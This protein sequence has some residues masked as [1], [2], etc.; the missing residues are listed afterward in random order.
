MPGDL[1]YKTDE[2]LHHERRNFL[3]NRIRSYFFGAS[4]K[5]S[6]KEIKRL[7]DEAIKEQDEL[8]AAE[9]DPDMQKE[10][11]RAKELLTKRFEGLNTIAN[12][13][14]IENPTNPKDY[15][16]NDDIEILRRSLDNYNLI[17][18]RREI[19]GAS[20]DVLE[21][22]F[23]DLYTQVDKRCDYEMDNHYDV[24]FEQQMLRKSW[25]EAL[26]QE[27]TVNHPN[28][29]YKTSGDY[30][31]EQDFLGNIGTV[32][33][34]LYT[35]ELTLPGLQLYDYVNDP[36]APQKT[37]KELFKTCGRLP[38]ISER[39]RKLY[40]DIDHTRRSKDIQEEYKSYLDIDKYHEIGSFF[41]DSKS[42]S[43]YKTRRHNYISGSHKDYPASYP[44]FS[45]LD[46]ALDNTRKSRISPEEKIAAED[47]LLKQYYN[48]FI[49]NEPLDAVNNIWHRG[50][51]AMDKQTMEKAIAA[52]LCSAYYKLEGNEK[53]NEN[54]MVFK[55]IVSRPVNDQTIKDT[56]DYFK[57]EIY[58][59]VYDNDVLENYQLFDKL[60]MKAIKRQYDANI[61]NREMRNALDSRYNIHDE[62]HA[63]IAA[64]S[65]L[66]SGNN[67]K[68]KAFMISD[69]SKS[70]E[71]D[72]LKRFVINQIDCNPKLADAIKE[73]ISKETGSYG[74]IRKSTLE[75]AEKFIDDYRFEYNLTNEDDSK[76]ISQH[77]D[78][79]RELQNVES[80][81]L[82]NSEQ[83]NRFRANLE[84]SIQKDYKT[85]PDTRK[86]DDEGGISW[87]DAWENIQKQFAVSNG[88]LV[89]V[90][91]GKRSREAFLNSEEVVRE[92]ERLDEIGKAALQKTKK[93]DDGLTAQF[94]TI[95]GTIGEVT[96]EISKESVLD[97]LV[98]GIGGSDDVKQARDNMITLAKNA[99][100]NFLQVFFRMSRNLTASALRNGLNKLAKMKEGEKISQAEI[101][102]LR[103][104]ALELK[105]SI[106]QGRTYSETA[107]WVKKLSDV[108]KA[109]YKM[110]TT[111]LKN[112]DKM[113]EG[114]SI[115][116]K[117]V[118][119]FEKNAKDTAAPTL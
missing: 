22:F 76:I 119:D 27:M 71:Y 69:M 31:E 110:A 70:D 58:K 94:S 109:R 43:T 84:K 19:K 78:K 93:T 72:G 89:D 96:P 105:S 23:K 75:L 5:D 118:E 4:L 80:R 79:L 40:L 88:G 91:I 113:L 63:Y 57:N 92:K 86:K 32:V 6:M 117:G 85:N 24:P 60:D 82:T 44:D 55:H 13:L 87:R 100:R 116:K 30:S 52:H 20:E 66:L 51:L 61:L 59:D 34:K 29:Y 25:I 104:K 111:I 74:D 14:A 77:D 68:N 18:K 48:N 39:G 38:F 12:K 56:I 17:F 73:Q 83:F 16:S 49:K 47:T 103:V 41:D 64:M 50:P 8:I 107:D 101:T 108:N 9:K 62:Y 28:D 3:L 54:L 53:N 11:R 114:D 7:Y 36:D 90:T 67:F 81:K 35:G 112:T 99:K 65:T 95:T 15:V 1:V 26:Q 115:Y 45:G 97:T 98:K 37:A 102:D 33:E 106:T 46:T 21:T 2:M 42:W 10:I